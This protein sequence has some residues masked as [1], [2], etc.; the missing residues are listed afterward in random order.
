MIE[1]VKIMALCTVS[2]DNDDDNDDV[3]RRLFMTAL[4]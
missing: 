2:D 3:P 4:Q 1:M